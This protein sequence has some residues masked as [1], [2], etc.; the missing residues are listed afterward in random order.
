MS[1]QNRTVA[2]A[3]AT[4]FV[5]RHIVAELLRRGFGVRAL[6]RNTSKAAE[7]FGKI[8]GRDRLTP[9]QAETVTAESASRLVE[10]A[11]ACI[12]C[13]GAIR[14]LQGQRFESLHV[15]V[16][17]L[18]TKACTQHSAD[19]FVQI[20]ALGADPD[21]R[22]EYQKTKYAGEGVVRRS[23]IE[24]TIFR[25]SLIVGVGGEITEMMVQWARGKSQP[26]LFMPYFTRHADG[27]WTL[28]P[29]ETV[30]PAVAPIA[31]DDLARA[32]CDALDNE[33]TIGEIFNCVGSETTSWPELLTFVRDNAKNTKPK[34]KPGGIPAPAAH[35]AA[36]VAGLVGMGSLLPYDA[37]MA[38]M[39]SEDSTA[40]LDKFQA[41]FGF[42]P[43]SYQ[44]AL[45]Q[46]VADL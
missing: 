41:Y 6:V 8:E 27:Q 28:M 2:V 30:D 26:F 15:R 35:L 4:G 23:G 10:G 24:W 17:E 16:P 46:A 37:G 1:E 21:G 19:R 11:D 38:S 43:G 33:D 22:A 13:I 18:L 29:G 12:N 25:P 7:V 36:T 34:I 40:S 32:A 5:G 9:I 14:E 44:G 45:R 31:V 3:G 42:T 39:A 20:S